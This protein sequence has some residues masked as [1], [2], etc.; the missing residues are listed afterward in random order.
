LTQPYQQLAKVLE[1]EGDERGARHVRIAMAD[2]LLPSLTWPGYL[3]RK[4][5][6]GTIA[7]G[8][9]PWRA[10]YWALGFILFGYLSF[11]LGY[12]AGVI[13]P[14][15]KDASAQF[16]L[17]TT[18]LPGYQPFNAFVYSLDTFL[19]IINLG[20]KDKW[21]P[22]P[23][24]KPRPMA[25]QGTWLGDFVGSY[26]QRPSIWHLFNSGRALRIYLWF[27]LLLGWVLI[28]LFAAGFT[29]VIRR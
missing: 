11:A 28:T 1:S 17:D 3:W 18:L 14:T 4:L 8:Y 21:M 24:L 27:H 15:D 10:L 6:K 26:L 19:P 2:D 23:N 12:R 20:L 29:G 7:Y 22:D 13:A 25:I 16:Q 9:E 5:L